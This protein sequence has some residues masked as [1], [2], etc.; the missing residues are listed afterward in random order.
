LPALGKGGYES[1]TMFI[2][3][4][5]SQNSNFVNGVEAE[6]IGYNDSI[7]TTM[8]VNNKIYYLEILRISQKN[9]RK[10]QVMNM[11]EKDVKLDVEIISNKILQGTFASKLQSGAVSTLSPQQQRKLPPPAIFLS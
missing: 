7:A 8:Q 3:I 6:M 1:T 4:Y 10:P 9:I 11:E 5:S 2:A